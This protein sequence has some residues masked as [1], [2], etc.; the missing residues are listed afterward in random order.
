MIVKR[1]EDTSL[2]ETHDWNKSI[3]E[4]PYA[5]QE[6]LSHDSPSSTTAIPCE[7]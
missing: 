3:S 4:M 1:E 5:I 7:Q 2:P 6:Y